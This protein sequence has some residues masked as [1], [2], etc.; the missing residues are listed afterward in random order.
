MMLM[1]ISRFLQP[2]LPDTDGDI[3]A[4]GDVDYRDGLD[5]FYSSASIDFDGVDDYMDSDLDLDGM[6]QATIMAWVKLDSAFE[7]N[8][9][10]LHQGDF[11]VYINSSN[12]ISVSLNG[13][14]ISVS[15]AFDFDLNKW[16]H[17]TV[18]FDS[19]LP[20]D[21]L[22]LYVSGEFSVSESHPSLLKSNRCLDS[23]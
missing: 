14:T 6:T 15:D 21:N 5:V 7:D 17:F 4:G 12:K 22:K 11:E 23:W 1:K 20:S 9:Y 2:I 3:A 19:S 10:I 18:I 16:Y 13:R 8:A